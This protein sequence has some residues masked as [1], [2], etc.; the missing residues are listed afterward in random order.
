[1][2]HDNFTVNER[3]VRY[4]YLKKI[5]ASIFMKLV[6]YNELSLQD[7]FLKCSQIANAELDEVG[8]KFNPNITHLIKGQYEKYSDAAPTYIKKVAHL[9]QKCATQASK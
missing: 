6:M 8:E 3:L 2:D 5:H 9:M 4:L 1:M 7:C